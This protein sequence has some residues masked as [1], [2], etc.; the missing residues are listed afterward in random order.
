VLPLAHHLIKAFSAIMGYVVV[1]V[2]VD[3]GFM[4][5][6]DE[7]QEMGAFTGFVA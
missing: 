5:V 7:L 6:L 2:L 3:D 1:L 4:V